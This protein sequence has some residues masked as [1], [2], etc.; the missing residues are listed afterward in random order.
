MKD[1]V[2]TLQS[3]IKRLETITNNL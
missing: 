3:E 2:G 1:F